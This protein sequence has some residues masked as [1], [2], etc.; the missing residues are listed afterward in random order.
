MK[1]VV[2]WVI[3][4]VCKWDLDKLQNIASNYQINLELMGQNFS[5]KAYNTFM[6]YKQ[7]MIM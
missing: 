4:Q 7:L 5:A 1:I 2:M 6:N 3:R